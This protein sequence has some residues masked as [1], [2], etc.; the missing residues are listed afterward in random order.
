MRNTSQ[1][2]PPGEV[3]RQF[4]TAGEKKI[5]Q[6]SRQFFLSSVLGGAY[7]ALGCLLALG[8]A[9]GIP[10]IAAANPGLPK[11]LFGVMFPLG[12]ILV[13]FTGADLF[14]SDCAI[15]TVSWLSKRTPLKAVAPR[16]LLSYGG[17][18]IGAMVVLF[19]VAIPSG[20]LGHE[21]WSAYF[22]GIA[23][24]K[25]SHSFLLSLLKG[26]GAN[27][28]VCLAAWMGTAASDAPGKMLGIWLPVMAFVT[29]G[30]EHSIANFFLIPGGMM[31]GST[32]TIIEMFA[33]NIIPVTLGNMLGGI[34]LVG[35]PQ[36][37]LF[38]QNDSAE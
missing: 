30:L 18:F 23:E 19:I 29:L 21:P 32:N 1:I 37:L 25:T 14:T 36:T 11:L 26:V 8:V 6:P 27:W 31:S 2:L 20:F 34:F 16:L 12:L 5:Q 3:I 35:V 38:L 17:N 7:V 15:F 9:G 22:A 28:L 13:V 24:G 4:I 10:G 33:T